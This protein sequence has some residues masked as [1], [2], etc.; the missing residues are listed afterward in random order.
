MLGERLGGFGDAAS[1]VF[2]G[3][4]RTDEDAFRSLRARSK[5]PVTIR[6]DETGENETAAEVILRNPEAVHEFLKL[7]AARR[8]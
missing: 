3:D 4:D 1:I 7:L 8:A 2:I 6:V 5:R